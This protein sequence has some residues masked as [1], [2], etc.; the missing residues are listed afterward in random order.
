MMYIDVMTRILENI[1]APAKRAST[2]DC[3]VQDTKKERKL[4]SSK[5]ILGGWSIYLI[6]Q[7]TNKTTS[8]CSE[9]KT[10]YSNH[11]EV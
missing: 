7:S 5:Q 4:V 11:K 10:N 9:N 6:M 2:Q 1:A 8:P 3:D